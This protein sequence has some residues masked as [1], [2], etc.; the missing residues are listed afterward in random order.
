MVLKA[1]GLALSEEQSRQI[2][3]CDDLAA[4]KKRSDA[5]LTAKDAGDIFR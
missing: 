3:A 2:D 5:A 1:R 4:L